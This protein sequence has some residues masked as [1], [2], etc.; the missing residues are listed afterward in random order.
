MLFRS[1]ALLV[2]FAWGL[3]AA[4]QS[5]LAAVLN[6]AE[7]IL[8]FSLLLEFC[9][10]RYQR[11]AL[12]F[13]ALWLFVLCAI[14]LILA[15]VFANETIAR[16]SLLTPGFMALTNGTESWSLLFLV[17]LAHFGVVVFLFFGWWRQWKK[18]LARAAV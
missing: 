8:I 3:A 13:V 17:L 14:P 16:I 15:G 12:G 5:Y 7:F 2:Q 9:R 6:L 10:L 11:R 4:W 1:L 18:L